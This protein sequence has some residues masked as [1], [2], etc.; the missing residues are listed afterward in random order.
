MALSKKDR[1]FIFDICF[2]QEDDFDAQTIKEYI[3]E[4]YSLDFSIDDIQAVIDELVADEA[5][6]FDRCDKPTDMFDGAS[7]EFLDCVKNDTRTWKE[8]VEERRNELKSLKQEN[9]ILRGI[10]NIPKFDCGGTE[11]PWW[12][13]IMPR[14]IMAKDPQ[15]IAH[16]IVGVFFSRES[17]QNHLDS[18]RYE[19][20]SNAVVY[21]FSGYWSHEYKEGVRNAKKHQEQFV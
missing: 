20:G 14:Q 8:I 16:C 2:N 4:F 3:A 6:E 9:E 1:C 12:A 7:D 5:V 18:R 21:C 10:L 11:S 17:A 19:Y 15:E 13:I